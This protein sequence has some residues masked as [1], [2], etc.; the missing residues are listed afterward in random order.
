MHRT[1]TPFL[2]ALLLLAAAPL[3]AQAVRGTVLAK[4]G[5]RGVAGATVQLLESRG[6]REVARVVSDSAGG[7]E[8]RAPRPGRYRLAAQVAG[9]APS[10][11]DPFVVGERDFEMDLVV[12]R[13][14]VAVEGIT[15]TARRREDPR[16]LGFRERSGRRGSG[17][18][19]ERE[20]IEKRRPVRVSDLFRSAPG[21]VVRTFPTSGVQ[22]VEPRN[23]PGGRCP[24]LFFLD[25]QRA[26]SFEVDTI[27]PGDVEGIEVYT[28]GSVPAEF[29]SVTGASCGVVAVWTRI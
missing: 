25:G 20:D 11:T 13:A 19:L 3:S 6:G 12:T 4:E 2:A 14:A 28:T 23:A 29:N 22:V 10:R 8:V 5:E 7:F 21:L 15:V 9:S 24:L 1:R 16:L 27:R 26:G 18:F 17:W